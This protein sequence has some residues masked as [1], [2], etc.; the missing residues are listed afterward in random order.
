MVCL[1]SHHAFFW[2]TK[3]CFLS[4]LPILSHNPPFSVTKLNLFLPIPHLIPRSSTDPTVFVL[5]RYSLS[6]NLHSFPQLLVSPTVLFSRSAFHFLPQLCPSM[7][8]CL[9][10]LRGFWSPKYFLS[11]YPVYTLNISSVHFTHHTPRSGHAYLSFFPECEPHGSPLDNSL[12]PSSLLYTC[13]LAASVTV[14]LYARN[15]A[16]EDGPTPVPRSNPR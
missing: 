1:I 2:P 8:I 11:V 3:L 5:S 13:S 9:A 15:E 12:I 4:K 7:S 14:F 10:C 6:C 16:T